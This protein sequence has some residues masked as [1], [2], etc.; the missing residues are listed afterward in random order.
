MEERVR[1]IEECG[2]RKDDRSEYARIIVIFLD[3]DFGEVY[4]KDVVHI[5]LDE[6]AASKAGIVNHEGFFSYLCSA[7][8]PVTFRKA[9]T[10]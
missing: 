6:Q 2:W 4:E 9:R 1:Y 3:F 7:S 8:L 10:F 5:P